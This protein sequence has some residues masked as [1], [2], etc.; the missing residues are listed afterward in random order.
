MFGGC[1]QLVAGLARPF[2]F[3]A[4]FLRQVYVIAGV[5]GAGEG[6]VRQGEDET[7]VADAVAVEHFSRYRQVEAGVAFPHLVYGNADAF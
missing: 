1:R 6:R 5:A 7:A 2:V 4:A 3:D